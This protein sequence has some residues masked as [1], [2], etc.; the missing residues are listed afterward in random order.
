MLGPMALR[1]RA[2]PAL[3]IPLLLAL[4]SCGSSTSPGPLEPEQPVEPGAAP[5]AATPDRPPLAGDRAQRIE[6][7]CIAYTGGFCDDDG[8]RQIPFAALPAEQQRE[9]LEDCRSLL[10]R[11]SDEVLEQVDACLRCE[12]DCVAIDGCLA[13]EP[14]PCE[15]DAPTAAGR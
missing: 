15:E 9:V 5:G 6:I 3:A 2:R 12:T 8:V 7:L 14:H 13:P 1:N 10:D 11:R 4:V